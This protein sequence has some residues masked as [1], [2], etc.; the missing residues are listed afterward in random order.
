MSYKSY[1]CNLWKELRIGPKVAFKNGFFETDDPQLQGL[2]ERNNAFGSAIHFKDTEE[3]MARQGRVREEEASAK[4]A[5]AR[6][7]MLDEM[8]KEEQEDEK[9]K[10]LRAEEDREKAEQEEEQRKIDEADRRN[11]EA[12][13]G[14]GAKGKKGGE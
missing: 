5:Q 6:Q 7:A 10:K 9:R 13:L 1:V 3:E 2:I 4:R 8:K 12:L 11:A 14:K